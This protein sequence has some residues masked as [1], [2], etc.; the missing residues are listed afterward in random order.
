[1]VT[2]KMMYELVRKMFDYDPETGNLVRRYTT[3][4]RAQRG[5]VVGS[6]NRDGYLMVN[7]TTADGPRLHYVHRI[8]WLWMTGAWPTGVIDHI[9]RKPAD[10]RW[11][12][13]RDVSYSE[14]LH[15]QAVASGV[16]WAKRDKVWIASIEING[17]KYHIGQSKDRAEAEEMYREVKNRYRPVDDHGNDNL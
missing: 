1:M 8:I 17:N 16:Y 6:K 10:N 2:T 12:N 13:L 4:S 3:S 15:N 5:M 11:D 14:N 7:I 9:N